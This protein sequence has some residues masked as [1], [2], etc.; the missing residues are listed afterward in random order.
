MRLLLLNGYSAFVEEDEKVLLIKQWWWLHCE[1][2]NATE[3]YTCG[4]NDKC[5]LCI[6]YYNKKRTEFKL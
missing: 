6:F 2:F 4:S 3:L 5:H 1:V